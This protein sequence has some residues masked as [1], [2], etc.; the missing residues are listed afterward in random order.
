MPDLPAG[1]M[2]FIGSPNGQNKWPPGPSRPTTSAKATV[3]LAKPITNG[4]NYN[5][6]F[7]FE[8]AGQVSVVVP[9]SAPRSRRRPANPP[10]VRRLRT[11]GLSDQP[12]TVT[13]VAK[14]RSQYRCSECRH[15]TA[16]WVGR[17]LECGTW[18]TVD[19][20]AVLSAVGTAAVVPRLRPRRRSDQFRRA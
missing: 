16:K 4:P 9:I 10:E 2:L 12:D 3:T 18:G 15:V 14:A 6:T 13:G 19:E 20:V 11:P 8:K 7:N 5:F 17:C 1:G